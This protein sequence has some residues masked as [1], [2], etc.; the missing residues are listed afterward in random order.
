MGVLTLHRAYSAVGVVSARW[1]AGHDDNAGLRRVTFARTRRRGRAAGRPTSP[2]R[3]RCLSR[4]VSERG[5]SERRR[6][7][8][9][10]T[11]YALVPA[12]QRT[13]LEVREMPH[14]T[15]YPPGG[16]GGTGWQRRRRRTSTLSLTRHVL[17]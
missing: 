14:T 13:I 5:V 2:G 9:P 15:T 16:S 3:P 10:T 12:H 7:G 17:S 6:S 8:V 1:A 11:R 4:G